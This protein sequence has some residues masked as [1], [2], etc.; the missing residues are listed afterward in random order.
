MVEEKPDTPA[1][2]SKWCHSGTRLEIFKKVNFYVY[3]TIKT[4]FLNP[5]YL[6]F[7]RKVF[8]L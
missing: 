7:F 5:F 8:K 6:M 2:N 1:F 3:Y 4:M